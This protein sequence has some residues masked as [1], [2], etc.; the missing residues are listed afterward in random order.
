[1]PRAEGTARECPGL[2][3]ATRR[4]LDHRAQCP[5]SGAAFTCS[6]FLSWPLCARA[7]RLRDGRLAKDTGPHPPEVPSLTQLSG[8]CLVCLVVFLAMSSLLLSRSGEGRA[9]GTPC[10]EPDFV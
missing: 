8:C 4:C 5:R 10:R 9:L 1:M 2:L 6:A 3:A 7:V